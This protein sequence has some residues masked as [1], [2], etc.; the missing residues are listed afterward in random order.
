M[1]NIGEID[2]VI[3]DLQDFAKKPKMMKAL[4]TY[5]EK[6]CQSN[7]ALA[8]GC[9][10]VRHTYLDFYDIVVPKKTTDFPKSVLRLLALEKA[11][12]GACVKYLRNTYIPVTHV[13]E[14]TRDWDK[15]GNLPHGTVKD[16][17][18]YGDDLEVSSLSRLRGERAYLQ[19]LKRARMEDTIDL[20][21]DYDQLD[22]G[23]NR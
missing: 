11:N 7:A 17:S 12:H 8:A 10:R 2:D 13:L 4:R 9:A 20:V 19:E 18:E 14:Y 3:N 23:S 6:G 15:V 5:G 16:R 21:L 1:P 22:D